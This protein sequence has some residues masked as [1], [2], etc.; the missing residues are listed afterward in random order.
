MI[1]IRDTY[2][3]ELERMIERNEYLLNPYEQPFKPSYLDY[4]YYGMKALYIKLKLIHLTIQLIFTFPH[5]IY[6]LNIK[7][8]VRKMADIFL[9]KMVV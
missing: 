4:N 8:E 1:N 9:K 6:I 3:K 2:D 7:Q 5:L